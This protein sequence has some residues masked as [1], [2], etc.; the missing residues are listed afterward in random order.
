VL[1]L[2][3]ARSSARSPLLIAPTMVSAT[4]TS[5]RVTRWIKARIGHVPLTYQAALNCRRSVIR[6]DSRGLQASPWLITEDEE[7]HA[8][9]LGEMLAGTR[10][11][12]KLPHTS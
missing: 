9:L 10:R 2:S 7:L 8:F 12:R 3:H 4:R 11:E 1:Y 5:A 6:T